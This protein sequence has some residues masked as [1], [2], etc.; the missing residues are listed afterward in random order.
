MTEVTEKSPLSWDPITPKSVTGGEMAWFSDST[1]NG[2]PV[3]KMV[4][5]DY[6]ARVNIGFEP[7]GR[8]SGVVNETH[9]R[10]G[11]ETA[12]AAQAWCARYILDS[13]NGR[14][15]NAAKALALYSYYWDNPVVG[16]DPDY[17]QY[18][19]FDVVENYGGGDQKQIGPAFLTTRLA[20]SWIRGNGLTNKVG[21]EIVGV[22]EDGTLSEA[23]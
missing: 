1:N 11:F 8:W 3:W 2:K 14:L 12:E 18:I 17:P 16:V 6:R 13:I 19:E 15:R 21:V 9:G 7:D 4:H 20:D 22:R 23:L 10:M 5:G